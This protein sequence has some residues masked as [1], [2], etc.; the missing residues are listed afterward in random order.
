LLLED[1]PCT[2]RTSNRCCLSGIDSSSPLR[3]ADCLLLDARNRSLVKWRCDPNH[4]RKE[5]FLLYIQFTLDQLDLP[6]D[7]EEDILRHH[8]VSV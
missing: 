8:L 4:L 1:A 6:M 5:R 7:L 3:R 2:N